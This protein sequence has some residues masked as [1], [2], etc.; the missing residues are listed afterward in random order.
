MSYRALLDNQVRQAFTLL[1][2]LA[3]SVVLTK[4]NAAVFDFGTGE[5]TATTASTVTAKIVVTG[6]IKSKRGANVVE[7]VVMLKSAEI[8]DITFYD[9]VEFEGV[10][11]KFGEPI[12]NEGPVLITSI[13]R[14]V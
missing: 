12:R 5:G 1:K 14:E 7:K 10:T 6:E 13:Y 2:D 11:W 3:K 9:T 8:G 4:K